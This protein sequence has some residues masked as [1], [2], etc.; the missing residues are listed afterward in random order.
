M[1]LFSP[2]KTATDYT[3]SHGVLLSDILAAK[4]HV[5]SGT[6]IVQSRQNARV[7]ISEIR[8]IRGG[9]CFLLGLLL[10]SGLNSYRGMSPFRPPA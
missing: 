4:G 5:V 6:A 10:S 2:G 1:Y 7:E 3:D 9:F 8:V